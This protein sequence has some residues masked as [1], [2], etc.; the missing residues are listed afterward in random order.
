MDII[1]LTI[2][3][4]LL[5]IVFA[6][7]PILFQ[8]FNVAKKGNTDIDFNQFVQKYFSNDKPLKNMNPEDRKAFYE[9]VSSNISDMESN[10]V[11][12]PDDFKI[13]LGK[14]QKESEID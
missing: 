2:I 7:G 9:K 12:F 10:G 14:I 1:V 3:I 5:F 6:L 8:E 4:S 11:H 13:Q